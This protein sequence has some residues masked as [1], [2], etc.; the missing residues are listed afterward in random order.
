MSGFLIQGKDEVVKNRN[1]GRINSPLTR[2]QRIAFLLFIK[3]G[4]EDL[5]ENPL[6]R[7]F[8][9]STKDLLKVLGIKYNGT[10]IFKENS[11]GYSLRKILKELMGKVLEW[12]YKDEKGKIYMTKMTTMLTDIELTKEKVEF[13]FSDWVREQILKHGNAYIL[14]LNV[15]AKLRHSHAI[16]LYEMIMQLK[17][18]HSWRIEVD[19][20]KSLLG[21][22]DKYKLTKLFL[23]KALR[24]AVKEINDKTELKLSFGLE[25]DGHRVSHIIFSWYDKEKEWWMGIPPL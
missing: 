2:Q 4:Y 15:V 23:Q 21:V 5:I 22:K 25:R 7:R 16:A 19:K 18:L 3:K 1:L 9:V 10:G 8:A 11:R 6:K 24:P 14:N 17:N 20:L 12:E 13:V